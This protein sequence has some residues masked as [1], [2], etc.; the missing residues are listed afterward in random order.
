MKR[1]A[2]T[3]ARP[4]DSRAI[5]TRLDPEGM[6]AKIEGFPA[7]LR[8]GAGI[9]AGVVRRLEPQRPRAFVLIGMGGSAI[10]GD[11]LRILAD[12]E[13]AVPVHVVR[14]Y[15][16]PS[17]IT[18]EDF[19]LFSSYSGET[20]E[21]L[22]AYRSLS[23]LGCRA[24]AIASGG[25]L[26][27]RARS[28]G[29][30]VALLPAGFPPRAALGYSFSALAHIAHHLGVLADAGPRLD[31][32]AEAI[33]RKAATAFSPDVL[34]SRNPAK[35]IAIRLSGH[36]VMLVANHRTAEPIAWRWKG[37]L[38]ENS[39]HLAWVS[40]LPEMSHN[41]VDGL[42][43]PRGV[44]GRVAAVLL[45]DAADHPR[46]ARRFDWLASYLKKRDI[47]VETVKLEGGDPMTRILGGVS[48]G[49]FVSY[50]LALLNRS[51]PSALPGVTALKRALAK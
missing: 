22:S 27:E 19:L 33:E 41:E 40:V 9:A 42:V 38:N 12:R 5:R 8:A 20:E 51:D 21:T 14:H 10:A 43:N 37:Q 39:K 3:S 28:E 36:L 4:L 35:R 15:E 24:A 13:G 45:R 50:Y 18:P 31:A 30:P 47:H 11:L 25:S 16:P 48:L 6:R 26:A 49:D 17:W 23:R 1:K 46:I 44:V 7:Q 34:E 32:A 29:L 2:A